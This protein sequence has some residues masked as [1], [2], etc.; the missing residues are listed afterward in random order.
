MPSSASIRISLRNANQK[1]GIINE[2]DYFDSE[3]CSTANEIF[4]RKI[5]GTYSITIIRVGAMT[6]V[7]G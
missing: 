6:D 2:F 3:K 1:V 5:S 7:N 4:P